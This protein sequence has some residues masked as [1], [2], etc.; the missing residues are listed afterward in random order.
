MLFNRYLK[1]YF[2]ICLVLIILVTNEY[3][4]YC[5]K[6]NRKIPLPYEV[7]NTLINIFF[8]NGLN[9]NVH[10]YFVFRI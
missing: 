2:V 7:N 5:L 10:F 8:S 1:I 9:K 6:N 4:G 3:L